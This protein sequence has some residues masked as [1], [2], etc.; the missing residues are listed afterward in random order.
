MLAYARRWDSSDMSLVPLSPIEAG[1]L[2]SRYR[3]FAVDLD[4]VM[5]RGDEPV[6]GAASAIAQMRTHGAR[7]VF[8]TNNGGS[9]PA[10]FARRL[11][12]AGVPAD[13]ADVITSVT[14]AR[15]WTEAAGLERPRIVVLGA[16]ALCEQVEDFAS[17][18]AFDDGSP[19]VVL[20]GRDTDFD[21][22]TLDRA[23]RAIRD[24]AAFLALNLDATMPIE[25]GL[26]PGTGA[27]AAAL[28]V[29]SGREPIVMG[30]PQFAMMQCARR[31][32]GT[33]E[34][35]MIGDRLDSD[36]AGAIQIG[37]DAALVLTGVTHHDDELVPEPTY[38]LNSISDL[39]AHQRE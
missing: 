9:S 35:L 14:V 18:V 11:T 7:V 4:G 12:D 28:I 1:E 36:I 10:E 2:L 21:F 8:L 31:I 37:W 16:P 30:K 3:G 17:V 26:A 20:L 5:W 23:S 25:G 38:L 29:A 13:G 15:E 39:G 24:G 6:M 27:L 22:E 34:A 33:N 32:L 19:D